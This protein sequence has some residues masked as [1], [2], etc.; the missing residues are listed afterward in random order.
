[1]LLRMERDL[2]FMN[3]LFL[4]FFHLI[5]SGR[6]KPRI[7]EAAGTEFTAA[8]V[9]LYMVTCAIF[10]SPHGSK[11]PKVPRPPHCR[12]FTITLTHTTLGRTPLDE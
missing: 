11:A 4:E 2:K 9:L 1:V 7:T 8:G 10:F 6:G 5:F 12:S 3:R